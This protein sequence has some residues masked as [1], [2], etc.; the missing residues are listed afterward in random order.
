MSVALR[1]WPAASADL[2][3]KTSSPSVNEPLAYLNGS[4]VPASAAQLPVYDAGV[5]L[6]AT[7][8]ELT[9]TFR[10]QPFRLADHL[11]RLFGSLSSVGFELDL[12][13][14]DIAAVSQRLIEHN[15]TLLGSD[16][17]LGLIQFVTAGEYPTYAGMSAS[18]PRVGPTICLH[19][20]RLPLARWAPAMSA[21]ARLVTPNVRQ[22]P[23]E[24]LPASV[25]YRSRLHYYLADQ[26]ARKIDAQATAL[27]LDLAGN[28][29]ETGAANFLFVERGAIISPTL[30]NTLP[31]ISRQTI[32]ELAAEVG[33]DFREEDSTPERV[34]SADEA[35]L[36]STPYCLL[37]VSHLNGMT[38]GSA[39]RDRSSSDCSRPGTNAWGSIS[40]SKFFRL[41]DK[42]AKASP[43]G[44]SP[45]GRASS[46]TKWPVQSLKSGDSTLMTGHARE[47]ADI[48][49]L[50]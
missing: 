3:K 20:F 17:E 37:P 40:A 23:P 43:P 38:I 24:C 7:V 28:I 11:A 9:R 42:R 30:R 49:A 25:K 22:V 2:P 48:T 8:T 47:R 34:L 35:L 45:A 14:E 32:I 15:G 6:G 27:L 39:S 10:Q 50:P 31:G 33:I 4:L 21:G 5:V 12:S 1:C 19:T 18:A 26:E 46:G 41:A 29:T 16:A 44:F 36:T 13:S